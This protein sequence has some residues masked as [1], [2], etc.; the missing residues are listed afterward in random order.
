MDDLA[1]LSAGVDWIIVESFLDVVRRR[2][3]RCIR[4]LLEMHDVV[5]DCGHCVEKR[6]M[7]CRR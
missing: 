5:F 1:L 2:F 3:R 7:E 6:E 4:G